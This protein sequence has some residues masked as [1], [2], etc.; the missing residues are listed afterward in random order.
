MMFLDIKEMETILYKT[1]ELM[2]ESDVSLYEKTIAEICS[3][4]NPK[5][6]VNMCIGFYDDTEDEEVMFGLVHAIESIGGD[7]LYW[8]FVGIEHMKEA[9]NWSKII[10]YR[11][12]NDEEGIKKV[13]SVMDALPQKNRKYIIDLLEEIKDEDYDM[14]SRSIDFI[15]GQMKMNK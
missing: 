4:N 10:L 2:T 6:I 5:Y 14:F 11:I 15:L 12:L 8:T 13:P 3:Y 9:R 1:R 7:N